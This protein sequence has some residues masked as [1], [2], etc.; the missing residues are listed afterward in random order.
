MN[1]GV[2]GADSAQL[3][4]PVFPDR[5]F[6]FVPIR[7]GRQFATSTDIPTYAELP[8][9][10]GRSAT[11]AD[12]VG[13]RFRTYRAHADPEFETFTY[14]DVRSPRA[15]NL[16]SATPGD[17]IWFL[18]RLSDHDGTG[19]VGASAFH[20]IGYYVVAENVEIAIGTAPETLP[21]PVSERIARNAHYRRMLAGERSWFR[22]IVG[23]PSRSRRFRHALRV[24]PEVAGLIYGGRFDPSRRA[25]V[26]DGAILL[27]RNGKPR[28]YETFGSVTRSIQP[29][30]DSRH[31]GEYLDEL[32]EIGLRCGAAESLVVTN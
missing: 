28:A 21:A 2:N 19:W 4:S 8:A 6:E 1:V 3:R 26:R 14:G 18:A 29:F 23:D 9:W 20:L 17:E 5:T 10:T 25:Y 15:A 16:G 31:D 7:E 22:V 11:L 12:Y 24:T 27:N 32:H 13:S 30:L